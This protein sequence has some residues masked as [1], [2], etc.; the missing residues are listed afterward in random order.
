MARGACRDLKTS[1]EVYG[2][3]T[4]A[5]SRL[6]YTELVLTLMHDHLASE[7]PQRMVYS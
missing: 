1:R 7:S 2:P 6:L 3:L 5:A 4:M